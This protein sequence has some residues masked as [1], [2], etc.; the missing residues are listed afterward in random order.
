MIASHHKMW[1]T[2]KNK[3]QNTH[4]E[5][6]HCTPCPC[7][8]ISRVCKHRIRPTHFILCL[9][10]LGQGLLYL[11]LALT[12]PCSQGNCELLALPYMVYT[13]LG[14]EPRASYMLGKHSLNW[15]TV[16][17]PTT[18]QLVSN[19]K[20]AISAATFSRQS[21]KEHW[22]SC[23]LKGEIGSW[24]DQT[25]LMI[26]SETHA[27]Y[28]LKSVCTEYSWK[29]W[30]L[31]W[32]SILLTLLILFLQKKISLWVHSHTSILPSS[33]RRGHWSWCIPKTETL[34]PC[35]SPAFLCSV[36]NKQ[37]PANASLYPTAGA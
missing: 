29:Q 11:R 6:T 26:S 24:N 9:W 16:P 5:Q 20:A 30:D 25:P 7:M 21:S 14:I 15:A 33:G 31:L 27:L 17:A 34:S 22:I 13:A 23:Y 12:P 35:I 19:M 28:W 36:L 8:H 2:G 4:M 37:T 1:C 18:H 3:E 32:G 10:F